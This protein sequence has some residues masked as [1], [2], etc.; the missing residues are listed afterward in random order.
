MSSA[1]SRSPSRVSRS[2]GSSSTTSPRLAF[3]ALDRSSTDS[4]AASTISG[5]RASQTGFH[6]LVLTATTGTAARSST[7]KIDRSV[8]ST[9]AS[10]PVTISPQPRSPASRARGGEHV[11]QVLVGLVAAQ[12]ERQAAQAELREGAGGHRR[13]GHARRRPHPD[14][15][16][17]ALDRARD[18]GA[19][20]QAERHQVGAQP[21]HGRLGGR[22]AGQRGEHRV[23]HAQ[24]PA[25]P[26]LGVG[27]LEQPVPAQRAVRPEP[28][29]GLGGRGRDA[30]ELQ[31]QRDGR[32]RAA[33]TGRAA[34]RRR[35]RRWRRGRWPRRATAAARRSGRG[36]TPRRR[37][38][39]VRA[40]PA[41]RR[42]RCA[43]RRGWRRTRPR[44][45]RRTRPARRPRPA[46]TGV[47][48]LLDQR[49]H[50]RRHVVPPV[51]I[52]AHLVSM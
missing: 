21:V 10:Q 6:G 40:R 5:K 38:R 8:E 51:L 11:G 15:R 28:G 25:Q 13:A 32:P 14:Q 24:L 4:G 42:G 37:R 3:Q 2:C 43:A 39:A 45:T 12:V 19:A 29:E 23:G 22:A 36:R 46:G 30:G 48:E 47:L 41:G 1:D 31:G 26:R 17:A 34:A 44:P 20:G 9:T 35:A 33:R 7:S 27:Q 52:A 16:H 50:R 49:E 18:G